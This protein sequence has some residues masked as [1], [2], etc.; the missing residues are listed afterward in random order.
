[1]AQYKEFEENVEVNGETVLS[2]INSFPDFMR[3][4]A[5]EMLKSKG[6]SD[7]QAGKW[8]SQKAWLESFKEISEDYGSHTLFA[9]GKSIPENA[10]FPPE[11]D[12]LEKALDSLDIA[13][14]MNHRNGDI[15][16]YK[17]VSHDIDK[18][19]ILIQC[20]NPY[21]C[22]FDRGI[23]T[24]I[25]RKFELAVKVELDPNKPSRKDGADD[26]WYIVSY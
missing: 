16:Y 19:E 4:T 11:I 10:N 24:S 18:K 8:Y 14:R 21:P 9:I 22:D 25:S 3:N 6:I 26:S 17:M 23:I 1:M 5:I 13:Y 15:G 20:K 7:P 2:T 12:T